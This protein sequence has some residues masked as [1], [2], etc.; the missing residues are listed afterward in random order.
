MLLVPAVVTKEIPYDRAYERSQAEI[1][2]VLPLA[3]ELEIRIACENVWNDFLLSPLEA[4][5]YVDELESEWI[6]WYMD[7]GNVVNYGWP[8]QWIRILGQ[9]VLKLDVKEFSRKKRDDE[10]LWKG[11]GV[12]LGEGDCD[13]PAIVAALDEIGY[14]GWASAEV[15]GGDADRLRD[16]RERMDR[17][18]AS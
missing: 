2:A 6:G 7:I 15:R 18:L 17:I 9:R 3:A 4:A 12:E 13:W 10:G 1:R 11:F 16:I 14:E 8:E 5:R